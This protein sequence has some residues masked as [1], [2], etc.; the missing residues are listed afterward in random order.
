MSNHEESRPRKHRTSHQEFKTIHGPSPGLRH[1]T[2]AT[3]YDFFSMSRLQTLNNNSKP[4]RANVATQPSFFFSQYV[5]LL[6]TPTLSLNIHP[7]T[8]IHTL[9]LQRTSLLSPQHV[10]KPLKIRRSLPRHEKVSDS[11][12]DHDETFHLL[13]Y[14]IISP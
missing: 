14:Q 9:T 12:H 13:N 6:S 3:K 10:K 8:Q 4:P 1:F 7:N 2:N 11:A 5:H